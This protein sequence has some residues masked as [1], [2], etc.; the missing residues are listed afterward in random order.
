MTVDIKITYLSDVAVRVKHVSS[1]FVV[2][3]QKEAS[4][5][6]NII[7]ALRMLQAKLEER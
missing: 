4:R 6:A 2:Q 3:C 1:G 5:E 7:K